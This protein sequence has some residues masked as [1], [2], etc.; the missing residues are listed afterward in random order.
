MSEQNQDSNLAEKRFLMIIK[1]N[2]EA[3]SRKLLPYTTPLN[4]HHLRDLLSWSFSSTEF[5]MF[6]HVQNCSQTFIGGSIANVWFTNGDQY[7]NSDL[8]LY[9]TWTGFHHLMDF[10]SDIGYQVVVNNHVCK[11][12]KQ[13]CA[14]SP[15]CSIPIYSNN[16]N[17]T[18]PEPH[19]ICVTQVDH[20]S[21]DR[22]GLDAVSAF[23]NLKH[24]EA[25]IQV[26]V[27]EFNVME[28]F[29][30]YHSRSIQCHEAFDTN[31]KF[32]CLN[33]FIG[34]ELCCV[35]DL[36]DG[37]QDY[38]V[39]GDTIRNSWSLIYFDHDNCKVLYHLVKV[40]S[41]STYYTVCH[42]LAPHI[43]RLMSIEDD[44]EQ[45]TSITDYID[46]I[47]AAQVSGNM[48]HSKAIYYTKELFFGMLPHMN[49]IPSAHT[50]IMVFIV[51]KALDMDTT[52]VKIIF[53]HNFYN[54]QVIA[55]AQQHCKSIGTWFQVTALPYQIIFTSRELF[56]IDVAVD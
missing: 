2:T 41:Q 6:R 40:C 36:G 27:A 54:R 5:L 28:I 11:S 29:L 33:R 46:R 50:A 31:S 35:I 15:W 20:V 49:V 30:Q 1:V 14:C 19:H 52:A 34:D 45:Y 18:Y 42:T 25:C 43:T 12:S 16:R 22:Y 53:G 7:P 32:C 48:V 23:F 26:M 56:P 10:L 21:G 17:H 37:G 24:N 3:R 51:L 44:I 55:L 47:R 4:I 9:M 38:T 13:G 8:D 39:W